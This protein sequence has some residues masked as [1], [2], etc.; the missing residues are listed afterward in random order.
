MRL[1]ELLLSLSGVTL[2]G[3]P[4]TNVIFLTDDSREVLPGALFAA[5]TGVKEDGT[6]YLQQ[7]QERGA[8]AVLSHLPPPPEIG[9]AHV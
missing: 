8:A 5:M 9:R 2:Y 7:A 3:D 4:E 6:R 1:Q